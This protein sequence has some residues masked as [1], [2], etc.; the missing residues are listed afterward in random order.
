MEQG[1]VP[2]SGKCYET[3]FL[4]Y[5]GAECSLWLDDTHVMSLRWRCGRVLFMLWAGYGPKKKWHGNPA[6]GVV[7]N[8]TTGR[9]Y[10]V[11]GCL[12]GIKDMNS[13][14]WSKRTF[15]SLSLVLAASHR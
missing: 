12:K 10:L 11:T 1:S 4:G 13:G 2:R 3:A 15:V 5:E 6:A 8:R 7:W 9:K 14:M